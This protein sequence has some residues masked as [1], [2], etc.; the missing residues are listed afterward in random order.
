[1]N[2]WFTYS[3][4]LQKKEKSRYTEACL[5]GQCYR[6]I[7]NSSSSMFLVLTCLPLQ[8]CTCTSRH[9]P[10]RPST[11]TGSRPASCSREL[12]F[13][14]TTQL[15]PEQQEKL[16][17]SH[18]HYQQFQSSDVNSSTMKRVQVTHLSESSGVC[19]SPAVDLCAPSRCPTHYCP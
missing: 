11:R 15:I 17:A 3:S 9:Q 19:G 10:A 4:S 5:A 13:S 14:T 18:Q 2:S 8:M 1:M 16:H 6:S 12:F 7:K